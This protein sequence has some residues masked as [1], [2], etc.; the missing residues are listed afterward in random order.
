MDTATCLQRVRTTQ[1]LVHH[2]TNWVTIFDCAQI[3]KSFGAS[4]VMAHASEEVADMTGIASTLVLNIGTITDEVLRSMLISCAAA[5][6][7]QIPVVLDVCG[8]GAT[9]YRDRVV[10]ELL[11]TE[12][13]TVIKG[14]ASEVS[15]T[16]GLSVVTRG[17]DSGSVAGG[18]EALEE[19]ALRLA[20]DRGATVVVT[21]ATDIVAST[22]GST[23][24]HNG[25]QSMGSIVGTGCMATSVIGTFAGACDSTHHAAVAALVCYGI[26]GEMARDSAQGPMHFKQLLIDAAAT[27]TGDDCMSRGRF[28]CTTASAS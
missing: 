7:K 27:L 28:S 18:V 1:P 17:V 14:N 2:I 6:E 23:L 19:T 22:H 21:G 9:P 15:R 16:A 4:P 20:A 10:R 26:C 5:R 25:C 12:S 11:D 13:I 8:A 3:T 24:I